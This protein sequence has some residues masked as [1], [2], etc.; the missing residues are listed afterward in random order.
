M[1]SNMG[2][3]ALFVLPANA[4]SDLSYVLL[5]SEPVVIPSHIVASA[6]MRVAA[7]GCLLASDVVFRITAFLP[8]NEESCC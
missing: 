4:L 8:R 5:L 3:W 2:S 7:F 1:F 6:A